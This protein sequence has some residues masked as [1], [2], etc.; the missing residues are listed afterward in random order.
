[1][2]ANKSAATLS[3]CQEQLDTSIKTLRHVKELDVDDEFELEYLVESVEKSLKTLSKLCSKYADQVDSKD[4]D[5]ENSNECNNNADQNEAEAMKKH[6]ESNLPSAPPTKQQQDHAISQSDD[7][8]SD[9]TLDLDESEPALQPIHT[10]L[11]GE[12]PDMDDILSLQATGT[13]TVPE[14]EHGQSVK[15]DE[16]VFGDDDDDD[17]MFGDDDF[18]AECLQQVEDAERSYCEP[19][20]VDISRIMREDDQI[21]P[22]HQPQDPRYL[23]VLKQYFGYG[24]FRP[25]QWKI[26]NS[27]LND[28]RDNCVIMA[29]GYGK[30][31]CY[32]YPS[33]F[34]NGVTVVVSPL[35][36][37][38]QDQVLSLSAVNIA[39]CFLGSAQTSNV[40]NDIFDGKYRIVYMTPEYVSGSGLS[41]LN[42]L[43]Q[44]VGIDLVA[45]D[46]AHCVSQWGHDFRTAY[47]SLGLIRETL[48]KVPMMALTAT[49]TPQVCK[50]MC[51]SLHLKNP[52]YSATG[53]DR[54]NLYL[55]VKN[56][57]EIMR[58]LREELPMTADRKLDIDGSVIIYCPTKKM[59]ETVYNTVKML[60]IPVAMYHAG[61]NPA[62]RKSSHKQFIDDDVKVVVATVAFGMG[63]DKPDVRKV[64]HYGAPKDIESYYQEMGRAGRDGLPA[65]CVAYYSTGDFATNRFLI[66]DSKSESFA[67]HKLKMLTQMEQ[68]L[69]S[70]RC[71]RKLILSHF[72]DGNASPKKSTAM[73][74]D[75]CRRRQEMSNS[76]GKAEAEQDVSKQAKELL[77]AITIT[78]QKFGLGKP[79]L[80]LRGSKN[81]Q[82]NPFY[83]DKPEFGN[84]SYKSE[85]WWKAFAR[86][87]MAEGFLREE[88]VMGNKFGSSVSLTSE[89]ERWLSQAKQDKQKP[90]MILLNQELLNEDKKS[91]APSALTFETKILPSILSSSW[92][93]SSQGQAQNASQAALVDPEEVKLQRDLYT[94]LIS[95][96]NVL[97]QEKGIPSFILFNNKSLLDMAKFRPNTM[98]NL[99]KLEDIAVE[100]AN[101]YGQDFLNTIV[102]FCEGRSVQGDKMPDQVTINKKLNDKMA[103]AF[104][105]L[106]ETER[107]SYQLFEVENIS[108]AECASRRGI[109]PG[110]I[111]GHLSGAISAGLPVNLDKAGLTEQIINKIT[112]VIRAPPINSNISRL[113]PI[114]EQLPDSVEYY[115][116][117]LTIALL[118]K[119]FGMNEEAT[120]HGGASAQNRDSS[121]RSPSVPSPALQRYARTENTQQDSSQSSQAKRKLPQWMSKEKTSTVKKLKRNN[122]LFGK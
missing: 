114:K 4:A 1:M 72:E 77:L 33:V 66:G 86:V 8:D 7:E 81:Q 18:D 83:Y 99:L 46:E 122:S 26:I 92:I 47:R 106:K 51:A 85:K 61:M 21:N 24:R 113:T 117:K 3:K 119:K 69:A 64:I 44:R 100:K 74:C 28:K 11:V 82:L 55:C 15:R 41:T 88:K 58:D 68:Y 94:K 45:I 56:K 93:S 75:V 111:C 90:L 5:K 59:T 37:L 32:Q 120:L 76:G 96:R 43:N 14:S 70:T 54:P 49:A 98:D 67:K 73:C 104:M 63:I 95:Q 84:G 23:K 10:T 57:V 25:L 39:A 103:A 107:T 20:D 116:I 118:Q 50:D 29:T 115:H 13:T 112:D 19:A 40:I 105:G 35:I 102:E 52:L 6:K 9:G 108:L 87:I 60:H 121:N 31:L 109:L 62:D 12:T 34:T 22:E 16:D 30:S 89:G 17:D 80:F 38:M 53:F 27:V 78:G 101:K 91:V 79:I 48:P 71:R 97:S 2:A 65:E 110:T 36:S 42:T